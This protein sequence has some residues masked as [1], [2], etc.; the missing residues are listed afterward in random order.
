MNQLQTLTN[1]TFNQLVEMTNNE[2]LYLNEYQ[3]LNITEELIDADIIQATSI[4]DLVIQLESMIL[5]ENLNTVIDRLYS[6][7]GWIIRVVKLINN[8]NE[9]KYVCIYGLRPLMDH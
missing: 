5:D 7:N 1:E 4:E 3:I 9:I 2:L 8:D 6:D